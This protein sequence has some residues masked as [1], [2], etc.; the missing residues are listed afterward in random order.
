MSSPKRVALLLFEK[1]DLLDVGGPYEVFLTA[2]RLAVRDGQP[3]PFTVTTVSIDGKPRTAYGGMRLEPDH[4]LDEVQPDVFVVPGLVDVPAALYDEDLI[5]SI[6][7]EG[8]S[9]E[10]VASVCTGALLLA[11]AGLLDG[12]V[13]TTHFEDVSA[14][15]DLIGSD[16]AITARWV[17]AGTVVTGGGLSNGIAM[18]LH[19][20]HRLHSLD[21]A[22]RTARQIEYPWHPE[23]GLTVASEPP[24]G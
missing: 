10:I 7:S 20:V 2:N 22:Q 9:A 6:S 13:A 11:K 17:D 3:E 21:L 5:R 12:K 23:D 1:V 19:L 16:N 15:G 14:L 24:A 18:A 4:T 8:S